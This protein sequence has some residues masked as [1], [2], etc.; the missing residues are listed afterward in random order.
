[1]LPE[2]P[3][4]AAV[5]A[6]TPVG[7]NAWSSAA[8][9]RA[10]VSGL[11]QHPY[12]VDST[13]EPLR[14]ALAP[15]LDPGIAG[16][17]RFQALLYPAIDQVLESSA[18]H[19]RTALALALP[20]VRPGLDPE[21]GPQLLGAVKSDYPGV[22][23]ATALFLKGHAAGI[24]AIETVV[25]KLAQGAFDACVIA[26]V[27]SYLEPLTLEWLEECDQLHGAGRLNNA[28]GF[29]PGEAAGALLLVGP[30]LAD[31]FSGRLLAQV[32]GAATAIEH[33]RIKTETVCVGE[34]LTQAFRGALQALAPGDTISDVYCDMNGEPYR[35]D[36]YGFTALRTREHFRSVS[37]FVAP[38]DCWGDVSAAGALLHLALAVIAG[39]K[40]YANGPL[41]LVWASAEAGE[42]GATVL[43][44]RDGESDAR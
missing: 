26:G 14:V 3:Y 4:V 19:G 18:G 12:I 21:L 39:S 20:Q 10:G 36:E 23:D 40:G 13:G 37:Q 33:K 15:W 5:G 30:R 28:W 7:R 24:L 22:F 1:M 42:R 38:A 8:A 17:Q 43:R 35:A 44:V 31:Q 9:V 2:A 25:R 6:S 16:L 41:A 27:E 32:L 34:G 29:I 11:T